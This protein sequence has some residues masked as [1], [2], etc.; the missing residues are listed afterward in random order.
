MTPAQQGKFCGSCQKQVV[1]F[2]NMSDRQVAEFFKKPSTGSVCGRFMTDQL[3]R[4]IEIPR[5]RIP[6]LKYFFQFVIPAFLVS[7]KS[8]G[9]NFKE[10]VVTSQSV[11]KIPQTNL[12]DALNGK[13]LG[14]SIT[15]NVA[16]VKI[17]RL[18]KIDTTG[19]KEN[20][21][22]GVN[23]T[24]RGNVSIRMGGVRSVTTDNSPLLVIDGVPA[25]I[26]TLSVINPN[27]IEKVEI[28]KSPAAT[29]IYGPDGANGAIIITTKAFNPRKFIIKDILDGSR[30]AGA[31][32]SFVSE[33][34]EKDRIQLVANDSGIV[35]TDKLKRWVKYKISVSAVGHKPVEEFFENKNSPVAKEILL[36]RDIKTCPEVVVTCFDCVRIIRCGYRITVTRSKEVIAAKQLEESFTVFPNPIPK[37]GMLNIKFRTADNE[38]KIIR[39]LSSDGG[40]VSAIPV[41][42]DKTG[43]NFQLQ[44]DG[45]W[46]A[47]IYLVQLVYENGRVVASERIVIH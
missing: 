13:I 39:V 2:S 9:Q 22:N 17:T 28:I 47:G 8:S 24:V 6:W 42:A 23:C 40:V 16:P 46:A 35:I 31:S 34:D 37:G 38:K 4:D 33:S 12:A 26:S 19:N 43:N 3:D 32:V 25:M 18:V 10:V 36:N 14:P 29:A 11:K 44:T 1:D 45:R 21:E 20:I 30:I 7:L 5:K 41:N 15:S 27:T